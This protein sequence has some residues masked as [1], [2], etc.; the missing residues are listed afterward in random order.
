MLCGQLVKGLRSEGYFIRI[1]YI[2]IRIIYFF[3]LCNTVIYF[4]NIN[5]KIKIENRKI[6]IKK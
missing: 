1:I 5:I 4:I 3:L 6:K 2:N